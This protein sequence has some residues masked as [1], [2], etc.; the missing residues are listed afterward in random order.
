MTLSERLAERMAEK[1]ISQTALA[2]EVGVSQQTIGKLL[3]GHSSGS[4]HI[5]KIARAVGTSPEYLTGETDDPTPT[6]LSSPRQDYRGPPAT[7]PR[8]PDDVVPVRELDLTFGMG[9]TYLEVPVTESV[10]YISRGFLRQYTKADPEHLLFA[11]GIGDS[12]APT[13][14][15]SD[16]LLIDTSQQTLNIA[17]KIWAAAYADCG[18]IKRLRPVPGGGVLML[19]DNPNVP[20]AT[21]YDGELHLLGRVVAIMRKV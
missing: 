8:Y 19:A 6:S 15:D 9:A 17:D 14:L 2:R 5:H 21:A 4:S 20:D 12:M 3:T 18:T 13:I 16:G 1:R 11:T 10:R 7:V